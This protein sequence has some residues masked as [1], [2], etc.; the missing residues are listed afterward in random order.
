MLISLV[1]GLVAAVVLLAIPLV[2][3]HRRVPALRA[4][5]QAFRF[6]ELRDR[7]Q[8]LVIEHRISTSSHAYR[9]LMTIVNLGIRNAGVMKLSDLIELAKLVRHNMDVAPFEHFERELKKHD[10]EVQRLAADSFN[11]FAEMLVSNDHLTSLMAKAVEAAAN[12][13]NYA[14][15]RSAKSL[16]RRIT[17]DHA[18]VVSE[19]SRYQHWG[20]R[21]M[22]DAA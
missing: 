19:A 4:R 7:L 18:T 10:V 15:V 3:L 2:M 8:L 9:T 22:P 11:A 17:P 16:A 6:H 21:L 20:N 14:V 1:S 12:R 13:A 5:E